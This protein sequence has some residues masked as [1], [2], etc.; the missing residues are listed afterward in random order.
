MTEVN[1]IGANVG[2]PIALPSGGTL[3]LN[4]NG[5]FNY[6]PYGV[7]NA[8]PAAGSGA[9]NPTETVTFTYTVTGGDTATVTVTI[10]GV[11]SDD[12]LHG[13]AGANTL[14][15]GI[16]NDLLLGLAGDDSLNGGSGDDRLYGS[17]GQNDLAGGMG[18]D[19][20][21]VNSLTDVIIEATSAGTHDRVFTTVNYTL[22]YR[23]SCRDRVS[24]NDLHR[25]HQPHRQRACQHH[26]RQQQRQRAPAGPPATTCWWASAAPIRSTA[27]NRQLTGSLGGEANDTLTAA[28]R[29]RPPLVAKPAMTR[30][31]AAW[32]TTD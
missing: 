32:A 28:T 14:T 22:T 3:T 31:T 1:G 23:G 13:T 2:A 15:G 8:L 11:D 16:G 30:S 25:R 29:Q 4:A 7:F 21:I 20:Y 18:N 10:T 26:L 17:T 27:A 24:D 9:S 12:T 19:W 5:T 6:D